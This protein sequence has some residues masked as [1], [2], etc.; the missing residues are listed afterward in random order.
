ML[1]KKK[2]SIFGRYPSCD[3]LN[4]ALRFLNDGKIDIAE[5]EIVFAIEKAGGYFYDDVAPYAE[6]IRTGFWQRVKDKD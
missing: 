4:N 2:N 3:H 1:T 5:E 6:Q